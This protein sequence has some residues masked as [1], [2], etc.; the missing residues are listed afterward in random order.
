M[1]RL[2]FSESFS[3]DRVKELVADDCL[4]RR[5]CELRWIDLWQD[6]VNRMLLSTDENEVEV[7]ARKCGETILGARW[8]WEVWAEIGNIPARCR[9]SY[10]NRSD[11]NNKYEGHIIIRLDRI[12]SSCKWTVFDLLDQ[13]SDQSKHASTEAFLCLKP[14]TIYH[15]DQPRLSRLYLTRLRIQNRTCWELSKALSVQLS[16]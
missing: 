11:E 14:F 4:W 3:W 5:G 13:S 12:F 2:L 16:K 7:V 15:S 9:L 8:R 10:R 1:S 6:V